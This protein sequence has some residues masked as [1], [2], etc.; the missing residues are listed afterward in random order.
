[1]IFERPDWSKAKLGAMVALICG[2]LSARLDGGPQLGPILS[3]QEGRLVGEAR[4]GS[5]AF[6]QVVALINPSAEMDSGCL[7]RFV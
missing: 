5:A 4:Y 7:H 1:M 6:K 2:C 3:W